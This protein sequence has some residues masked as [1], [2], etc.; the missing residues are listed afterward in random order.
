MC[1]LERIVAADDQS[2]VATT[3][4][5]PD[6]LFCRDGRVGCWV[7]LECMAQAVAAWAGVQ[8]RG[9]GRGPRIGFLLGTRRFECHRPFLPLGELL[10]FE[11]QKEIQ[12]G[13]ALGQFSGKT[14]LGDEL[15]ATAAITVFAPDDPAAVLRG[16]I[17][18]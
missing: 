1:L 6:S 7:S 17:N 10:R 14:F 16:E 12:L 15:L 4:L 13:D 3:V 18:G 8:E 9:S 2:L 5:R 11:V